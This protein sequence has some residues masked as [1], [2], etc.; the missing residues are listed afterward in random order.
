MKFVI[1]I[2]CVFVALTVYFQSG[3][4]QTHYS[5]ISPG[6][7]INFRIHK[8][9]SIKDDSP[10]IDLRRNLQYDVQNDD[11]RNSMKNVDKLV[12]S[13]PQPVRLVN[14]AE[15]AHGPAKKVLPVDMANR[16]GQQRFIQND[17]T[18]GDIKDGRVHKGTLTLD[19]WSDKVDKFNLND[20][21]GGNGLMF[22]SV[23]NGNDKGNEHSF[24]TNDDVHVTNRGQPRQEL[25]AKNKIPRRKLNNDHHLRPQETIKRAPPSPV[26]RGREPDI[27]IMPKRPAVP[28]GHSLMVTCADVM[29]L[30][31]KRSSEEAMYMTFELPQSLSRKYK[32]TVH[33]IIRPG[34]I[35]WVSKLYHR[36]HTHLLFPRV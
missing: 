24:Q 23:K 12:D 10:P 5:A 17:D 28:E 9:P 21:N 1:T 14:Q 8:Q 4:H 3:I 33:I 22:N 15:L 31:K 20:H 29:V 26:E 16:D 30:A 7:L 6:Q 11:F 2:G 18:D 35:V 34:L 25:V 27:R 13:E 32:N 19:T 36:L